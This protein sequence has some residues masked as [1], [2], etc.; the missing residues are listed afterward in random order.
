[1]KP[2]VF[3]K[4]LQEALRASWNFSSSHCLHHLIGFFDIHRMMKPL[5]VAKI[6]QET[7][8]ASQS[9]SSAHWLH[10][11][12]K[13]KKIN[14]NKTRLGLCS[15]V[16]HCERAWGSPQKNWA[17]LWD[18]GIYHIGEQ[19]RLR[20]ACASSQSHLSLPCSL[21]WSIEVDEASDQKSDIWSRWMAAHARLKNEFTEGEKC[22][23]LVSWL[24]CSFHTNSIQIWATSPE[25]MSSGLWLG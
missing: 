9:F 24:S 15:H 18:Y 6:Q 23:N 7:L 19:R 22:H 2:L 12:M 13:V 21:T 5:V 14:F 17:S 20:R 16:W 11:P 25:N 10:H 8:H 1:M 4:I 3:A